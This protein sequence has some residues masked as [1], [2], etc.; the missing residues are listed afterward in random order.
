MALKISIIVAACEGMGIGNKG[1]LPWRL[2][3]EMAHFTRTTSDAAEDK[4]NAVIMGRKTWDS[5]PAKFKPLRNRE[6]IVISSTMPLCEDGR[7]HVVR[8]LDEAVKL[9]LTKLKD[10]I[11]KAFC[12]GGH[13]VYED[14]INSSYVDRL[15]LTRIHK[16]YECDVFFPEYDIDRFEKIACPDIPTEIQEENGVSYTYEVYQKKV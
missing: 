12:I 2:K 16:K 1:D 9:C 4:K 6:N 5:I 10:V 13:R 7:H 14:C 8:S 15:Y 3:K 11:D